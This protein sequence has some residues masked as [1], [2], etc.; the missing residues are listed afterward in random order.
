MIFPKRIGVRMSLLAGMAF[1]IDATVSYSQPPQPKRDADARSVF[2]KPNWNDHPIAFE[3]RSKPC[4]IHDDG[5]KSFTG[6]P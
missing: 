2:V 1:M 3:M 5:Q 6:E 4:R